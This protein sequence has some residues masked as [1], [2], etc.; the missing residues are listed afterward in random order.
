MLFGLD[1]LRSRGH[2]VEHNL[3]RDAPPRWARVAGSAVKRGLERAGGYGGDFATVL[4]SLGPANRADVVFSTV[5]TVGIPLVLARRAGAVAAA[6]RVRGHRAARAAR[7]ASLRA[8]AR[9]LRTGAR[10][11]RV[12]PR[13]QRARGGRSRG[14][15]RRARASRAGLVRALRGRRPTR[16]GRPPSRRRATSCRWALT[17]T[18]TFRCS[19]RSRARCPRRASR[20]SRDGTTRRRRANCPRTSPSRSTCRS[21]R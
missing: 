13:L 4:G 1:E 11:L 8:D 18:A 12:D 3:E 15:A 9:P 2:D 19:W 17:R 14:L 7:A 10:A 5:D 6:A 21:T 16:S 20:W